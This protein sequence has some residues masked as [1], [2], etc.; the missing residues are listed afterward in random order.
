MISLNTLKVTTVSCHVVPLLKSPARAF[1][2]F[3]V[4]GFFLYFFR[5]GSDESEAESSEYVVSSND[6]SWDAVGFRYCP[7]IFAFSLR[8]VT[9]KIGCTY[10]Y[11]FFES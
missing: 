2:D 7:G 5:E 11:I 9:D 8:A 3:F 6:S 1:F 4:F 10:K